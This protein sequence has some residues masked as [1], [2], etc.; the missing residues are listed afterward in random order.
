M[1]VR[2]A[3][4]TILNANDYCNEFGYGETEDYT[5]TL[6]LPVCSGT[7]FG[8][9]VIAEPTSFCEPSTIIF[10]HDTQLPIVAGLQLQWQ[11]SADGFLWTNIIGATDTIYT[12]LPL[13][14]T[15]LYRVKVTCSSSGSFAYS[16][17]AKII[18]FPTPIVSFTGLDSTYNVNQAAVTLTA[19]PAGGIFSGAGINGNIF[20]PAVAG[21]GG[22]YEIIYTY[23]DTNGCVASDTQSVTVLLP[24]GILIEEIFSFISIY[25]NPSDGKFFIEL[26]SSSPKNNLTL[27]IFNLLGKE[28]YKKEFSSFQSQKNILINAEELTKGNYLLQFTS[29]DFISRSKL[30]IQ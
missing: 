12:S 26:N 2:C 17:T 21:V 27:S 18:M 5:I 8:G 23:T 15:T 22:P 10:L 24:N 28:I 1:R 6:V 13:S 11:Q 16:N 14:D 9:I 20:D 4:N 30:V 25:P 7:P 29:D 3:Y 19:N